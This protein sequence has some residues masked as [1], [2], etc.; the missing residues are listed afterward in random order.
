MSL[1]IDKIFYTGNLKELI[2]QLLEL[3]GDYKKVV[4]KKKSNLQKP[5]TS[6]NIS[7]LWAEFE[8]KTTL[9]GISRKGSVL[10]ALDALAENLGLVPSTHLVA[11]NSL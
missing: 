1:F 5:A 6:L 9:A 8:T 4:F 10:K 3:M 7:N 11:H 2:R